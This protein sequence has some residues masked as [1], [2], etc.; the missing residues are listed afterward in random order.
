MRP[1]LLPVPATVRTL[2]RLRSKRGDSGSTTASLD[3]GINDLPRLE[4]SWA[5]PFQIQGIYVERL[6][7]YF[8]ALRVDLLYPEERCS[9]DTRMTAESSNY[10]LPSVVININDQESES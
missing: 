1:G 5:S 10:R 2:D 7:L 8:S 6:C 4:L 9:Q 3:P